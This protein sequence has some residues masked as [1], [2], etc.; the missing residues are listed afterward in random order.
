[1]KKGIS[2]LL[3]LCLMLG[4]MSFAVAEE[5]PVTITILHYMGNEVKLNAFNAIL[6]GYMELHP[7]VTFDSQALSQNEYITQLRTRVGAG[8]APDIM[9][10]QPSQYIDII[11]AGYVMDLTGNELIDKLGLTAADIG[12]C[13]WNGK[14]YA[15]PLDFKTYAVIYNKGIFAEYGLTEPTTQDELDAICETLSANGIDPWIRN[16]SNL[17]YPDIEIRAILWPLL[18]E[19]GKFDAFEKLMSGEA[20]WADYPEF[21]KALELWGRRMEYS[22]L[23]DMSN[24]TTMARQAM[25]AGEAAMIYD[26]T[27][28]YAQIQ[29]FN[30]EQ[31]YGMFAVPRDDGVANSYCVQ[32]DQ[33]FMVNGQ[34]EH[35]DEA[36]D[37]LEYLLSPDVAGQWSAAT[38]N[39]SVVPGVTVE[40]PEVI[41]VAMNAKETNNIAHAGNFTA[42]LSGEYLTNWRAVLQSFA[43]DR[44]LTPEDVVEEMQ[45]AFDEINASK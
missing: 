12:D 27:W 41:K 8:D 14:V 37:F 40:M 25:A 36:L 18:M 45:L 3:T 2:L 31:E 4:I 24:D 13:S 38:Y 7:N 22:R 9:M 21:T 32:L 20:Q 33:I 42:Q 44:T 11:E 34:S 30:P 39:P 26:G 29:G 6:D 15:L 43:A 1:M 10:G 5:E 35:V 23:D 17:T 19:N 16:Y 28:A